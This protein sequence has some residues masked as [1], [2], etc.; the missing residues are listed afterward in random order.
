MRGA[1]GDLSPVKARHCPLPRWRFRPTPRYTL[2]DRVA[3]ALQTCS[4]RPTQGEPFQPFTLPDTD[5]SAKVRM[6]TDAREGE[7]RWML[8]TQVTPI[9]DFGVCPPS[10]SATG[11]DRLVAATGIQYRR[12]PDAVVRLKNSI[13]TCHS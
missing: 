3:A 13:C 11:R 10:G 9:A 7:Y 2:F 4:A 8:L 1:A 12:R 5:S 6:H